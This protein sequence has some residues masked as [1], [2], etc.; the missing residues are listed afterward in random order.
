MEESVF[1]VILNKILN[2][3]HVKHDMRR[4]HFISNSWN[5][6]SSKSPKKRF[7]NNDLGRAYF[8]PII[9]DIKKSGKYLEYRKLM[10]ANSLS[11]LAH[12][13]SQ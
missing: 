6:Y 9:M 8:K 5:Y 4:I 13:L 11:N 2:D 7:L 10:G 12:I 1:K 3:S